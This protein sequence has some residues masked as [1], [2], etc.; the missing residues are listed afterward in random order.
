MLKKLAQ[1]PNYSV[2]PLQG[3]WWCRDMSLFVAGKKDEWEW[4]LM[5]MQPDFVTDQNLN[6]AVIEVEKKKNIKLPKIKFEKITE[7][8]SAQVMHIGPYSDEAVTIANLHKFIK[9]NGYKLRG[10]HHEIYLGDPRKSAPE[11]LKTII[12]Q[13]VGK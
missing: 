3:L 4:K 11:K 5:I 9:D 1:T 8:L 2:P 10:L 12:R 7:G 13:P 6:D